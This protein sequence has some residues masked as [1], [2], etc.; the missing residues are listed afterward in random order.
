ML[1]TLGRVL[2]DVENLPWDHAL[3]LPA[4]SSWSEGSECAVLDP[5][6]AEEDE[7]A[8]TEARERGL[9]Y[10]LDLATVRDIVLNLREQGVQPDMPLLVRA[11]CHYYDHD[12][13]LSLS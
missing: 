6:D 13:F 12:A 9:K 4:R 11:L 7:E 1:T 10:A 2:N 3:Y 5:D 8:P